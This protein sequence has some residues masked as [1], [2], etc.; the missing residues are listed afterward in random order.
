M[1]IE[2]RIRILGKFEFGQ[3]FKPG[4]MVLLKG[5]GSDIVTLTS[6]NVERDDLLRVHI[7]TYNSKYGYHWPLSRIDK[8]YSREE[9]NEFNLEDLKFLPGVTRKVVWKP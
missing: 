6:G 1:T 4:E 3:K 5:E 9:I 8:Y 2:R 7:T